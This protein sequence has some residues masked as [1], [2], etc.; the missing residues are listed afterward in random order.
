MRCSHGGEPVVALRPYDSFNGTESLG[1][2][3]TLRKGRRTVVCHL[4]TDP[5]GWELAATLDGELGQ[6]QVC[7]FE[8]LV[9]DTAEN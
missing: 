8:R 3:W 6:T 7:K 4:G 1:T 5:L 2:M 9:F